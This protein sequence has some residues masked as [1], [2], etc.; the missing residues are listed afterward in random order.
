[1]F[2]GIVEVIGKIKTR[3]EKD[4]SVTGGNGFSLVITDCTDILVDCHLGDS[5]AVNGVCLTVTEFTE[6]EFKV[7]LAPE[8]LEKTNLG[9]LSEGDPVNLERAVNGAVRFG[10]HF[11]QGHVDTTAEIVGKENDGNSI[12]F[13]FKPKDQSVMNYIVHKGFIAVDGT[14]LTVTD[15]SKE[16]FKI[17]MIAYTQTKVIISGKEIGDLVNIE[18]DLTGKLIEKQVNAQVDRIL[19]M[20]GLV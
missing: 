13:E 11:V 18:V 2:T 10:G 17:M 8:T 20:K 4:E 5:I 19:A 16:T 12:R 15:V 1:M 9:S 3:T 7:G 6:N 14:S